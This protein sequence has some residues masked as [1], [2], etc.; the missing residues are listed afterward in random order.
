MAKQFEFADFVDEFAVPFSLLVKGVGERLPNG[1]WKEGQETPTPM[2][3]IILPLE[4]DDRKYV[5]NGVFTER[6]RKLYTKVPMQEGARIEYKGV[7][8]T[9]QGFKDYEAYAD[10]YIYIA[11]GADK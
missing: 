5:A 11:R 4:E 8:Y 9:I 2:S 10:V 7:K 6:D 3:G 1:K